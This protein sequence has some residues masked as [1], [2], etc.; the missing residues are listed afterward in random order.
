M[1]LLTLNRQDIG[2]LLTGLSARS[3]KPALTFHYWYLEADLK[4]ELTLPTDVRIDGGGHRHY[5]TTR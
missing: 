1:T 2:T 4:R 3:L 5:H